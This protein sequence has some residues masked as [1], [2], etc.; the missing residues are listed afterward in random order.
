MQPRDGKAHL[1]GA[2]LISF[3]VSDHGMHQSR[4]SNLIRKVND[5][6][7]KNMAGRQ[8]FGPPRVHA[9]AQMD[10]GLCPREVGVV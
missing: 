8:G 4:L 1:P 9:G 6:N 5:Q 2:C 7:I 3:G 10:V